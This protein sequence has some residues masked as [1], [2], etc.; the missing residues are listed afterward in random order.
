MAAVVG[1]ELMGCRYDGS[2]GFRYPGFTLLYLD[3]GQTRCFGEH[4]NLPTAF[5][6]CDREGIGTYGV[7]ERVQEWLRTGQGV[8]FRLV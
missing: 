7:R 6:A 4:V 1:W 8:T 2:R 5:D 3:N